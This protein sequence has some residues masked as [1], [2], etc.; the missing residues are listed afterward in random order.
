[1]RTATPMPD[2]RRELLPSPEPLPAETRHDYDLDF[3]RPT[4]D[5][6]DTRDTR[7]TY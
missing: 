5:R 2:S 3:G 4:P 7:L 6:G 1:V